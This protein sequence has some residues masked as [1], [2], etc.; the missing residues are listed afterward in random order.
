MGYR[1]FNIFQKERAFLQ[2]IHEIK[3]NLLAGSPI[4]AS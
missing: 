3:L 1:A 4:A 2:N